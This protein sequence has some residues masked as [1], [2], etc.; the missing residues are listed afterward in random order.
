M[1]EITF[2]PITGSIGIKPTFGLSDATDLFGRVFSQ[3]DSYIDYSVD[4]ASKFYGAS[5]AQWVHERHAQ[6]GNLPLPYE[7]LFDYRKID[8]KVLGWG[9]VCV[10][11]KFQFP[12]DL[13]SHRQT[14]IDRMT[15]EGRIKGSSSIPRLSAIEV[16]EGVPFLTIDAAEYYDQ[17][18]TNLT[19]DFPFKASISIAGTNCTTVREWDVAQAGAAARQLPSLETSRLANSI[20]VGVGIS[21]CDDQGRKHFVYRFRTPKAPVYPKTWHLPVSFALEMD[22]SKIT[23]EVFDLEAVVQA[24]FAEE[25]AHEAQIFRREFHAPKPNTRHLMI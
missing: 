9:K 24:D 18:G 2:D 22:F 1:F 5:Q 10:R 6:G 21:A 11:G 15:K 25:L 8:T 23:G 13:S 17:V 14:M 3:R 16:R 7:M 12:A 4:H 19:I 20:G